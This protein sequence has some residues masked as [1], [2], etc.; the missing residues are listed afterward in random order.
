MLDVVPEGL[1]VGLAALQ[2]RLVRVGDGLVGDEHKR[3][4]VAP[5]ACAY[6]AQ[7][8]VA[9]RRL[10]DVAVERL[11]RL[12]LVAAAVLEGEGIVQTIARVAGVDL[13]KNSKSVPMRMY[14]YKQLCVC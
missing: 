13:Q 14:A 5:A 10:G 9:K 1:P 12:V 6:A 3:H 11:Q 4:G 2:Q 7:R 8:H